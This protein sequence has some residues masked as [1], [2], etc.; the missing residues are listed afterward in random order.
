M[1]KSAEEKIMFHNDTRKRFGPAGTFLESQNTCD[2]NSRGVFYP[3]QRKVRKRYKH[4]FFTDINEINGEISWF[5]IIWILKYKRLQLSQSIDF[6]QMLT[7]GSS[8]KVRSIGVWSSRKHLYISQNMHTSRAWVMFRNNTGSACEWFILFCLGD[9]IYTRHGYKQHFYEGV[10]FPDCTILTHCKNKYEGILR[11]FIVF[12]CCR[13]FF[14]CITWKTV[15]HRHLLSLWLI[16]YKCTVNFE[17]KVWLKKGFPE[18]LG[19]S[20]KTWYIS[21][22]NKLGRGRVLGVF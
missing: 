6:S 19:M 3:K 14:F 10:W 17:I 18:M 21:N 1:T 16:R 12:Y 8:D 15:P 20:C 9:L 4:I 2:A 13:F 22:A 7:N 11:S 5:S